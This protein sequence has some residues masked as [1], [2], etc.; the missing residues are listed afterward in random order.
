[1]FYFKRWSEAFNSNKFLANLFRDSLRK[2]NINQNC[3]QF[4]ENKNRKI[5][6][7]LLSKMS[8]YI[9]VIV[10]RGGKGL[11]TKVQKFSS[12]HVI[13]HLEGLCHIYVDKSANLTMAKNIITNAKNAKDKYLWS[14]RNSFN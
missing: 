11:V 4:I 9:D 6:D 3:V 1:M 8:G 12:V 10:P 2:N 5:V 13:G 7:Q 14:G